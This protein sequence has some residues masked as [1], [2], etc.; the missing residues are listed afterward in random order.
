VEDR[1]FAFRH[2]EKILLAAGSAVNEV[3]PLLSGDGTKF[4]VEITGSLLEDAQGTHYGILFT[5]QKLS[6]VR[7][8]REMVSQYLYQVKHELKSPLTAVLG[9]TDLLLKDGRLRGEAEEYISL[10]NESGG[11]MLHMIEDLSELP[12]MPQ[13]HL[14]VTFEW[15]SLDKIFSFIANVGRMLIRQSEKDISLRAVH[16]ADVDLYLYGD[17]KRMKQILLNLVSNAVKFTQT[18]MVEFGVE[19]NEREEYEFFVRDTGMGIPEEEQPQ[20]FSPYHKSH[21]SVTVDIEEGDGMGLS[22]T[23]DFVEA[24]GG[25][26]YLLSSPNEGSTFYFT[27]PPFSVGLNTSSHNLDQK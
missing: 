26:L 16:P 6:H 18:G 15:F 17:K 13:N 11:D 14:K 12:L 7:Q 24:M 1:H 21:N 19:E 4:D 5:L 2:Y 25:E 27:L 9:F 8:E 23:K 10:I 22:I 20:I 3:Y